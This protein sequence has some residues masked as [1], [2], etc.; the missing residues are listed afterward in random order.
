MRPV[1]KAGEAIP[2]FSYQDLELLKMFYGDSMDVLGSCLRGVIA[3]P[4]GSRFFVVDYASIEA[5]ITAWLAGQDDILD[6]FRTHGK[7][8]E[9]TASKIFKIPIEQIAKDSAE[10]FA[11]KAA[12]LSL[13]FQ[14]GYRALKKQ[15]KPSLFSQ[16]KIFKQK[17]NVRKIRK[18]PPKRTF[19]TRKVTWWTIFCATFLFPLVLKIVNAA[20]DIAGQ[21]GM[22]MNPADST[23][24]A[25][26]GVAAGAGVVGAAAVGSVGFTMATGIGTAFAGAEIVTV[27]TATGATSTI[28]G[29]STLAS[30]PALLY[31]V[32]VLGAIPV[33]GWII[34]AVIIIALAVILALS[35]L[36]VIDCSSCM[37][38]CGGQQSVAGQP[39]TPQDTSSVSSG[40]NTQVTNP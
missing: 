9:H 36:G 16:K 7:I 31:G 4:E 18:E 11:G 19:K 25:A 13:G 29:S 8:Y 1:I 26:A 33:I 40:T 38:G 27:V 15:A 5:R 23:A 39:P 20:N 3:A 6:V 37:S 35:L 24:G 10:R 12:T 17:T 28:F 14:G 2:L 22:P 34:L 21:T 32:P 30:I